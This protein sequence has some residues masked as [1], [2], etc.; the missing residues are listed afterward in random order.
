MKIQIS[1]A[2]KN[3]LHARCG[4]KYVV[5]ERGEIDIYVSYFKLNT[6]LKSIV[7]IL[8]PFEVYTIDQLD[9]VD[10]GKVF[11]ISISTTLV[12]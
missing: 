12:Y 11:L 10:H 1:D 2:M 8:S 7:D 3:A 6:D 5:Q 9:R 4:Q